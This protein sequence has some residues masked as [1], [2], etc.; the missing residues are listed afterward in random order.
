MFVAKKNCRF[1]RVYSIGETIP[2]SVI[3]PNMVERLISMG[4]VVQVPVVNE[5]V[6]TI[7]GE[8]AEIEPTAEAAEAEPT[9][10]L[11]PKASRTKKGVKSDEDVQL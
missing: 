9:T 8:A 6:E 11:K 7:L 3:D 4:A 5:D 1:D 2:L 10:E